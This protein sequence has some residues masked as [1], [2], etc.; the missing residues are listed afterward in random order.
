M[1]SFVCLSPIRVCTWQAPNLCSWS[2]AT[3]NSLL[4]HTF[5]S[6]GCSNVVA[7]ACPRSNAMAHMD[8]CDMDRDP[9]E[10]GEPGTRGQFTLASC[11]QHD[12][13][14]LWLTS[15][16]PHGNCAWRLA[17]FEPIVP[18]GRPLLAHSH[19]T[20]RVIEAEIY[21]GTNQIRLTRESSHVIFIRR[22][23]ERRA[24]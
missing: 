18:G 24:P 20:F 17:I 21:L 19:G 22:I 5:I 3:M 2:C 6:I 4:L 11:W 12:S 13:F 14:V 7:L 8:G 16:S 9:F 1:P 10:M 15:R 23:D